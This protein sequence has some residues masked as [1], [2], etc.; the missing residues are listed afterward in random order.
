MQ[1]ILKEVAPIQ[2][3]QPAAAYIADLDQ[4]FSFQGLAADCFNSLFDYLSFLGLGQSA[5]SSFPCG[6]QPS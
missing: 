2:D 5:K 6:R 1:D 3:I 4:I